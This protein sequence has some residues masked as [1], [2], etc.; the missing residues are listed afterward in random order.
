MRIFRIPFGSNAAFISIRKWPR[1]EIHTLLLAKVKFIIM[2]N[3]QTS[4]ARPNNSSTRLRRA[5][6]AAC[7]QEEAAAG[8]GERPTARLMHLKAAADIKEVHEAPPD[9]NREADM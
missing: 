8:G 7:P 4:T 1:T 3:L 9:G 6:Y 2:R 5:V